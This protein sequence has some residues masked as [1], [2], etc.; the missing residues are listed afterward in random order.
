MPREIDC[1]EYGK[2]LKDDGIIWVICNKCKYHNSFRNEE[3]NWINPKDDEEFNIDF[4]G[5]VD[6]D[7]SKNY[8]KIIN[9]I[10]QFCPLK[11][12]EELVEALRD[13]ENG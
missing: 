4:D 8:Q 13:G 6:C 10:I 3:M 9:G 5:C 2:S 12:L 7:Y 11:A 1:P